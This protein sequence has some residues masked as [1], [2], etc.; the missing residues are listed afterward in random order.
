MFVS[1]FVVQC[2]V[3]FLVLHLSGFGKRE[4]IA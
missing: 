3:L 1:C 2:F 4:L